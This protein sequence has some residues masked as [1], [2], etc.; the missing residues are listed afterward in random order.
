MVRAIREHVT[1]Q[2]GGRVEI[3][4]PELPAGSRAEV[5]VMVEEPATTAKGGIDASL[6]AYPNMFRDAAE[7]EAFIRDLR[8]EWDRP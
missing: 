2:P 8:D 5:I 4:N 1:I 6:G 3:Q 7:A